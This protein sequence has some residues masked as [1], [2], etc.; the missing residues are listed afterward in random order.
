MNQK[1]LFYGTV[2]LVVIAATALAVRIIPGF[3]ALWLN[4]RPA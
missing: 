1:L 4:E 3:K 2:A